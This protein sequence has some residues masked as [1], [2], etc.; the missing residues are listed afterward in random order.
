V[1][2]QDIRIESGAYIEGHLRPGFGKAG[3]KPVAVNA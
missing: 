2:H 3:S 1:L